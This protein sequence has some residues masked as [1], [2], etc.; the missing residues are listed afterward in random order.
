MFEIVEQAVK[1]VI[2]EAKPVSKGEKEKGLF[3]DF[4]IRPLYK[5]DIEK[6]Q[7]ILNQT[8]EKPILIIA[9]SSAFSRELNKA[10]QRIYFK[11]FESE[12]EKEEFIKQLEEARKRDHRYLGE[13][14][15]VFHVEEEV[16]GSGLPL[17]HFNGMI[18][19]N[20]LIKF[21]REV[22]NKL[23]F[24]EVFTPH[25]SK[26]VLWKISGHY[27]K[28]RDKMF[29]FEMDGDEWGLKP[30]NCPM[31]LM[32]FKSKPR[33]YRDMPFKF[34]EFATVYRKELSGELHG[35]ARVWSLTQDDHHLLCRPD[36]L[37]EELKYIIEAALEVYKTF[38]FDITINLSTRP[39]QYI[40]SDEIWELSEKALKE[41]LDEMGVNYVTKEG[42]GAF[43]GPKIDFDAKDAMGRYWQLAT[44]Q[45]DFNLPERFE[46]SYKDKDGKEKRPVM[47]HFAI[48]GSLE[49]FTA[50]LLEH[51]AGK[52][53]TWVS[54]VQV[55]ILPV[56]EKFVEYADKVFEE[57]KKNNI[58]V[59]IDVD[60]TVQY[61][62]R[63][64]EI[65]KI[66][67]IIVVGQ[68]EEENETVTLR[69]HGKTKE[70]KLAEFIEKLKEEITSRKL[71]SIFF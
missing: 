23:G 63:K 12:Q 13:L 62:V 56:S 68:K 50:L 36:Q 58:R 59:E 41:V 5:E 34:A 17:I 31:H 53:P 14:M 47:I 61:R 37:K 57:L 30:M 38:G 49:R 8:S 11:V 40:G 67:Y 4:L 64:A 3:V 48:L 25:L 10:T 70:V 66:P 29:V 28:Y 6:I 16:I 33:S 52:L 2:P 44:I 71:T 54:P 69:Y 55:K 42:E 15:D 9:H 45:V 43:Y 32:I 51:F 26:T 21:M 24:K 18:I 19:R 35:L 7:E 46:L 1:K 22:N 65:E 27:T 60:G 39:E 20:E